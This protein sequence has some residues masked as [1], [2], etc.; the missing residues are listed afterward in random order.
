MQARELM[1]YNLNL[2]ISQNGMK[3][4]VN[5]GNSEKSR[6]HPSL[7]FCNPIHVLYTIFMKIIVSLLRIYNSKMLNLL[8]PYYFFV[9]V[10][11]IFCGLFQNAVKLGGMGIHSKYYKFL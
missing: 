9:I 10:I 8:L 7:R 4:H 2:L 11:H 6:K 1:Q 5:G 3:I